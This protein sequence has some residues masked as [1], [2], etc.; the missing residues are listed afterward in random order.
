MQAG[1]RGIVQAP[2]GSQVV[3]VVVR[4]RQ[5]RGTQRLQRRCRAPDLWCGQR[6]V[7]HPG[8]GERRY[9]PSSCR[10]AALRGVQRQAHPTA[11][12]DQGAAADETVRVGCFQLRLRRQAEHGT[13][14]Q[15]EAVHAA[16]RQRLHQMVDA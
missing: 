13:P 15:H 9:E 11:G 5:H 4:H 1:E 7:V 16:G 12:A 2:A 10:A 6:D 3:V 14:E 8:P